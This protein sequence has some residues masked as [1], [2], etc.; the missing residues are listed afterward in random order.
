[1]SVVLRD[2]TKQVTA[3]AGMGR[4]GLEHIVVRLHVEFGGIMWVARHLVGPYQLST[5]SSLLGD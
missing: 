1:M 4:A 5:D 3:R 2:A